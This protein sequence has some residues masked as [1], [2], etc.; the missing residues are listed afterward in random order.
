MNKAS[1][2]GSL[3]RFTGFLL[4][5]AAIIPSLRGDGLNT[6]L[7]VIALAFFIIGLAVGL[8]ARGRGPTA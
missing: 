7:F 3:L 4:L 2:T 5:I 8:K 6:T 1:A